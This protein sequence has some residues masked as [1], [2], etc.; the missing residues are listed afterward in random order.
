METT[1]GTLKLI[2]DAGISKQNSTDTSHIVIGVH[3]ETDSCVERATAKEGL[4][5]LTAVGT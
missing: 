1:C 2:K 4:A 5:H 3:I